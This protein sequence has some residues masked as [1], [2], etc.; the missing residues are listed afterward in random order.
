MNPKWFVGFLMFFLLCSSVSLIIEK[1]DLLSS[2]SSQ[3]STFE[4]L[5]SITKVEASDVIGYATAW[6][7]ASANT[8][9]ALITIVLADYSFTKA[10]PGD[11]DGN[12]LGQFFQYFIWCLTFGFLVSLVLYLAQIVRGG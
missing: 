10:P 1:Q 12:M 11:P 5:A 9:E 3:V 8:T 4:K 7:Q 6:M 2:G